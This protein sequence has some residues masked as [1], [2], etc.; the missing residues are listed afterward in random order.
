MSKKRKMN[1]SVAGIVANYQRQKQEDM[2]FNI[3]REESVIVTLGLTIDRL[4]SEYWEDTAKEKV[5][6]FVHGFLSIYSCYLHGAVTLSEIAEYIN[7]MSGVEIQLQHIK[8]TKGGKWQKVEQLGK[9]V[10]KL[11]NKRYEE[12]QKELAHLTE[13]YEISQ[14]HLESIMGRKNTSELKK[15]YAGEKLEEYTM[16]YDSLKQQLKNQC[17]INTGEELEEYENE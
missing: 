15:F 1:N 17:F 8:L 16:S 6:E 4:I 9:A 13:M 5:A 7:E 11:D 3:A 14:K 12:Y 10:R 2:F